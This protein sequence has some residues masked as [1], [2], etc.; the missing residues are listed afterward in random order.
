MTDQPLKIAKGYNGQLLLFNNKIRIER[1]GLLPFLTQG[2][3]GQ[4]DIYL[5]QISSIQFKPAGLITNGYIQ[6]AFIG[7]SENKGGLF[8]AVKDE[9]TIMF[10]KKQQKDFEEIRDLIEELNPKN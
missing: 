2:Y 4:K 6:F 3:K 5:K 9:N 1:K 10:T 8:Q 7:G